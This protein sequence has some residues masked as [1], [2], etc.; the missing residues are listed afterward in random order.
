MLAFRPCC[1]FGLMAARAAQDARQTYSRP[2][3]ETER[4]LL[5]RKSFCTAE[6]V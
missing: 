3:L 4:F 1:S 6:K 5:V 2:Q